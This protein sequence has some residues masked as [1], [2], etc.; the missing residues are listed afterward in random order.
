MKHVRHANTVGYNF[1]ASALWTGTAKA[2]EMKFCI[3]YI[4]DAG[5]I[6]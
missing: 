1:S 6:T 4:Q 5:A 2:N 3:K